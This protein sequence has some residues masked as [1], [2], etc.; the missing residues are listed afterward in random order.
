MVFILFAV[1][2]N[3]LKESPLFQKYFKPPYYFERRFGVFFVDSN[4]F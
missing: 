1:N 3:F 4:M 2:L